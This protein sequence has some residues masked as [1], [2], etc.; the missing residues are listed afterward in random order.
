[1]RRK[2]WFIITQN[3]AEK[4]VHW[5]P[6]TTNHRR[7]RT[8][9]LFDGPI[10]TVTL[11]LLIGSS[12]VVVPQPVAN[13]ICRGLWWI[14][15]CNPC[16]VHVLLLEI[17]HQPHVPIDLFAG[18]VHISIIR[19]ISDWSWGLSIVSQIV[20]V[21][22]KYPLMFVKDPIFH[23]S[24]S[25]NTNHMLWILARRDTNRTQITGE[26]PGLYLRDLC[27]HIV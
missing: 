12:L 14:G 5:H 6:C 26:C 27:L 19:E 20:L 8:T 9:R 18:S 1:M 7:L 16:A 17:I 25:A 4:Q 24:S 15:T 10:N 3:R 23:K 11:S 22:Y 13:R 21:V 2:T